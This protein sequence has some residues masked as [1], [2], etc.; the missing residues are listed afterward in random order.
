MLHTVAECT[1]GG[2]PKLHEG[3]VSYS[4]HSKEKIGIRLELSIL[5]C[6]LDWYAGRFKVSVV[7]NGIMNS[8]ASITATGALEWLQYK[9][10][11]WEE[12]KWFGKKG[13]LGAGYRDVG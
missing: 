9:G 11:E 8:L 3:N 7:K 10:E 4:V 2:Q 5:H 6:L 13:N 1:N 12:V